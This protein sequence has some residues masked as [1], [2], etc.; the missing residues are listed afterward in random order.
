VG[1]FFSSGLAA[2]LGAGQRPRQ[3][4]EWM[5]AESRALYGQLQTGDT[6]LYNSRNVVWL[7]PSNSLIAALVPF[8][9]APRSGRLPDVEKGQIGVRDEWVV[10]RVIIDD[11]RHWRQ[12]EMMAC[13]DDAEMREH[14]G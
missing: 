10:D 12:R 9:L 14:R 4:V 5:G 13:G 6:L 8:A 1:P 7:L 11:R 2:H 3:A